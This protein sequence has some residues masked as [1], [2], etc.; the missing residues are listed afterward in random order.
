MTR[1]DLEAA[2]FAA[3]DA[4]RDAGPEFEGA[5]RMLMRE[6]DK[7]RGGRP[8]VGDYDAGRLI[9]LERRRGGEERLDALYPA[10]KAMGLA[11]KTASNI[12][13]TERWDDQLGPE[14]TGQNGN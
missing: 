10:A 7:T 3:W 6:F 1:D 13:S 2:W 14:G 9:Y 5:V 12:C 8:R 4:A 11:W